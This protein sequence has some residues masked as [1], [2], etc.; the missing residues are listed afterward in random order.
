MADSPLYQPRFCEENIWHLAH[1]R[2]NETPSDRES[3]DHVVFISN[4]ER[5]V[6]IW[7]QRAASETGEPVIWDYHVVLVDEEP[8]VPLV[9][10]LDSILDHPT[11]LPRWWRGSFPLEDISPDHLQPSFRIVPAASYVEHFSSDRSHMQISSSSSDQDKWLADP[12]DWDPIFDPSE[13]MNLPDF[14]DMQ[15]GYLGEVFSRAEFKQRFN[16]AE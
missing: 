2:L 15:H 13:G 1:R 7:S 16:L 3:D 9:W 6:A 12:P 11:P 4:P 8:T 5:S 14:V 10:D